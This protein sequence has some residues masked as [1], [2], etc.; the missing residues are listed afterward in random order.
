MDVYTII[1][2]RIIKQ[3][4]QGTIPWRKPWNTAE[5]MPKNLISGK[6]YR[7]INVFLLASNGY[8]SPYWVSFKQVSSLGGTVNKGEKGTP[9]VYWNWIE[10]ED[11]ETQKPKKI[12]FIRYY[13]VFNVQQTSGI[14]SEKIPQPEENVKEFSPI[15]EA[16]KI[17][18]SFHDCPIK[19]GSNRAF[20]RPSD[21]EIGMPDPERFDTPEEYYSTLF[22]E[23]TH[24]TGHKTRL[25]RE[26]CKTVNFGSDTYS[27]EELTAEMGAAFLSAISGIVDKTLD[28]SAAYIQ[29][30]LSR[31][32]KDKKVV[33]YAA[34]QAQ[35]STD[36]IMGK[37]YTGKEE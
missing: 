27:K 5:G 32:K 21:D 3:L 10:K 29:G 30:W 24:S 1:T 25:D 19:H 22:H 36:H 35:K 23:M 16:D 9:V 13:T 7:G 15:D 18:Q 6:E 37:S 34:S 33:I 20:Y 28:N 26:G 14:P 8:A 31:L 4:E 2:D 12:P 11:P 17:K